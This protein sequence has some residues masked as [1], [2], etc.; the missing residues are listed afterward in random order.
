MT[1]KNL[2]QQ[3]REL[4]RQAG[5]EPNAWYEQQ[6]EALINQHMKEVIGEDEETPIE[7]L[8]PIGQFVQ[9]DRNQL[10]AEQRARAGLSE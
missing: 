6:E 7:Q 9:S 3:L 5:Y 4:R 1:Q 10:R 2:L 8:T